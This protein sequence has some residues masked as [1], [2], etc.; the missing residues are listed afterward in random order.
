MVA[1]YRRA[2]SPAWTWA[3]TSTAKNWITPFSSKWFFTARGRQYVSASL[4]AAVYRRGEITLDGKKWK[5][6]LLDHNSN[7]RFDDLRVAPRE[8]RGGQPASFIP[9]TATCCCWRARNP[10]LPGR[11]SG[12]FRRVAQQ[13][14]GKINN[15]GGKLYELKVTPRG[16]EL[17][18]T[19][20]AVALGKVAARTPSYVE[21]IGESQGYLS[22]S[23]RSWARP[24][25]PPAS[26]GC[27]PTP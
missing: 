14:L 16:D 12:G 22:L 24:R 4:T 9:T 10:A 1:S 5:V 25:S 21:L 13:Y 7:G 8:H 26:G 23:L 27:S 20:S 11:R 6:A 15:L 17:T 2:I 3:S 19:P 18:V